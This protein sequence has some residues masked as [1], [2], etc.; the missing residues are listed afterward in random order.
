MEVPY[1]AIN[2]ECWN[3]GIR[4]YVKQSGHDHYR[5][6]ISKATKYKWSDIP[7]DKQINYEMVDGH[8]Y[9][10]TI[11][12]GLYKVK[13]NLTDPKWED[14]N[15]ELYANFYKKLKNKTRENE[16]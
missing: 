14:K 6:V 8:I 9:S 10:V 16:R 2:N 1:H 15:K 13:P 11:G 7:K 3:N 4:I 5:I 12:E